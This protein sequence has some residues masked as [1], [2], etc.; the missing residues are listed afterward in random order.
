MTVIAER[1]ADHIHPLIAELERDPSGQAAFWARVADEKAPLIEPDPARPGFS[2][3]TFVFPRPAAARHVVVEGPFSDFSPATAVMA[4]VEDTNVC[5]ATY[6]FRNDVRTHYAFAPDRPLATSDESD[7]PAWRGLLAFMREH[8]PLP[9]PHHRAFTSDR[10]GEGK[11]DAIGSLLKLAD[12]PD[13]S[14]ADKRANIVRGRI[15][16]HNFKSEV[17]GNE[18]RV[19]VY[20]PP[21]YDAWRRYP[22]IVVF[23]GGAALTPRIAYSTTCWRTAASHPSSRSSST[24]PPTPRAASNCRAASLSRG[25][26]RRS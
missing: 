12:A 24:T 19:W 26:S 5:H 23:D 9:D 16:T 25:S 13:Q 4:T 15:E 17:L 1:V 8:P 14:I 21:G 6:R 20:T 18:R 10:M 3:V 7:E 11:P 22:V 2:L